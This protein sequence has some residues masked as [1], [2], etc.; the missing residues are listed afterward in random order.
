M[1]HDSMS[2]AF[3]VI[4][5]MYNL[6]SVLPETVIFRMEFSAVNDQQLAKTTA[7]L[8]GHMDAVS[9]GDMRKALSG[10]MRC[11]LTHILSMHSFSCSMIGFLKMN[12]KSQALI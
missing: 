6:I 10:Q 12:I 2:L 8:G 5:I 11:L 7:A 9:A 4:K 1:K 3:Q